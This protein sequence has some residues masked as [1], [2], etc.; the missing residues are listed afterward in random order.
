M[1]NALI[2]AVTEHP[3]DLAA[4][5]MYTIARR[6][7]KSMEYVRDPENAAAWEAAHDL[8][9]LQAANA[10]QATNFAPAPGQWILNSHWRCVPV[11]FK[12]KSDLTNH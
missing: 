6:I 7:R 1:T 12:V 4:E 3:D 9:M 5:T 2:I 8:P 10:D 11:L